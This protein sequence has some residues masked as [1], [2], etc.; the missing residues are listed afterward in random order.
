MAGRLHTECQQLWLP[1]VRV[2]MRLPRLAAPK[3]CTSSH[4]TCTVQ[5]LFRAAAQFSRKMHARF[6]TRQHGLTI[7][8]AAVS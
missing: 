8:G 4:H 6:A 7:L 3:V 2:P 5:K 1:V